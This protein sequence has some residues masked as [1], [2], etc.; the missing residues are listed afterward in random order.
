MLFIIIGFGLIA[1]IDMLPLI[2]KK[3]WKDAAAFG[4]IFALA[5]AIS[6]LNQLGVPVQSTILGIG[7]LMHRIGLA[8]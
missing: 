3:E 2:R 6:V 5:L 7:D 8:Y 1:L 4:L